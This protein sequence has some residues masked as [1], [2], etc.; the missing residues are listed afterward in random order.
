MRKEFFGEKPETMCGGKEGC[1]VKSNTRSIHTEKNKNYKELE[2]Y[3]KIKGVKNMMKFSMYMDKDEVGMLDEA[4][5]RL[6]GTLGIHISRNAF[7]RSLLM[8]LMNGNEDNGYPDSF[9]S[10]SNAK[11]AAEKVG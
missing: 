5:E 9:K 1:M 7:L 3:D 2:Y 10:V 8:S 4:R 11:T 6:M